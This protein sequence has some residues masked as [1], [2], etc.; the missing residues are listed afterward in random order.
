MQVFL[1]LTSVLK[2]PSLKNIRKTTSV[3]GFSLCYIGWLSYFHSYS[4][5][6]AMKYVLFFLLAFIQLSQKSF[7]QHLSAYRSSANPYYWKNRIPDKDYWQQDVYYK[8]DARIDEGRNVIEAK[9]TLEYWNNSPDTLYFV[10]FHLY[11]NAFVKGSYLHALEEA[12]KI[13]PRLGK[14][15]AQGLGTIVEN[16]QVNK[17][18]V[19]RTELDNTILKVWLPKPLPPQQYITLELD[20]TTYYDR[21]GTRRRMQMWDAWG[22]PHYNGAQWYPKLCVYDREFGWDTHQHL[23]KE[24]YG[25]FG[26]FDVRL[27]F[28]SNYI[29]EATGVLQNREEVLPK[30]LREKIDL[31]NFAHKKWGEPPSTIIPYVKGERKQWHFYAENVHDFAFVADP[32]YRIS[33]VYQD[34]VECVGIAQEPHA[35]GWQQS[36]TLV[37][38][39]IK[40]FSRDFGQ[41]AYPK[42]IAADARDGME[43]PMLTMDNGADPGYRGLLVHEI[44]HNWFYGMVGNNETYRAALDE[45]FTQFLTAWGLE[46]IDGEYLLKAAP[47]SWYLRYFQE[48]EKVRDIRVYNRYILAAI[49]GNEIPLNTHSDDFNSA[50][51]H[52]GGYGMVYYKTAAML[53]NLQYVLGDSLFLAAMQHYVEQWKMAHPY[54]GDFRKSII[55][56]TGVDLNWFFDQWLETTKTMDYRIGRIKKIRG[57]DSFAIHIKRKGSMQSPIDFTVTTKDGKQQD[58]HIPNTWFTKQ[59]EAIVLPRWIGWGKLQQNYI[60][61]V[62]VPHGIQK[63]SIDTSN[64]LADINMLDNTKGRGSLIR[65][66][67]VV[68]KADHGMYRPLNRYSYVLQTRPDLWWNPIDGVKAGIHLEG[69]YMGLKHKIEANIWWNTHLLQE[70]AYLSYKSEGW[71]QRYQPV[72]F[73]FSYATPIFS[74]RP[75]QEIRIKARYLDGLWLGQLG[76]QW[77]LH[78]KL[79]AYAY[80]QSIFRDKSYDIDYLLYPHEWSSTSKNLNNT[81]NI[82]MEH[83]HNTMLGYCKSMFDL[84]TPLLGSHTPAAFDYSYVQYTGLYTSRIHKAE[85]KTR[86]FARLGTGNKIPYESSLWLS[87][88]NPELLMD[89]KYTRSKGFIPADWTHIAPDATNHFQMGGGMNLRGYAGYFIADTHNG[90]VLIGYKGRSGASINV[91]LEFDEYIPLKP[92]FTKNWLSLDA[93][94]FADAGSIELSRID[95]I[96][97]FYH[98]TPSNRWSDIRLDA[99]IGFALTIKKWGM[100]DKAKPLTLRFDMPLLLNRPPHAQ[101]QYSDFRYVIGINRTF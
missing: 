36:A 74:S 82:H 84:R 8:I 76:Y 69:D 83:T 39:I 44:A 81:L 12:Q 6:R 20:F 18:P 38:E 10:Y 2:I 88:A 50:L 43:Y 97:S 11:Q 33:T 63:V 67:S 27:D 61:R 4:I 100:L 70:D 71:Y 73:S 5:F 78:P 79:V 90:E 57:T 94:L 65:P 34:G 41:Y 53:Y 58:Y 21:G 99:G 80:Y 46:K 89:N 91:E 23:N 51:G 68:L 66:G 15:E 96:S 31:K 48:P 75:G 17:T 32:S 101:P 25:D 47:K 95:S 56:F 77:K 59:T 19:Y 45:G 40:T 37:A 16:I 93:Y 52:G 13:K 92:K 14:Y 22:F 3:L 26:V 85:I 9:Q 98:T 29:V 42:M 35:S 1:F 72:H 30:E 62:H 49:E 55:Q 87:G 64:R 24:F 60:A 54:F 7:G 28:P 86:L